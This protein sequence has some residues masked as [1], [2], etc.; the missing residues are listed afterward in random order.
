MAGGGG[1]PTKFSEDNNLWHWGSGQMASAQEAIR[2]VAARRGRS[3]GRESRKGGGAPMTL[4]NEAGG[5]VVVGG[6]VPGAA[7]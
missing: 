5:A 2:Y 6:G 7:T 1:A 4:I 3:R